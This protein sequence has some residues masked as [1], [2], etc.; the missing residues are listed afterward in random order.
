MLFDTAILVASVKGKGLIARHQSASIN[1][2]FVNLCNNI[3]E[4]VLLPT[5]FAPRIRM[6][7]SYRHAPILKHFVRQFLNTLHPSDH[8][9]CKKFSKKQGMILDRVYY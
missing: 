8:L 9:L 4:V 6:I 1:A 7:F 5:P 2:H 3:S